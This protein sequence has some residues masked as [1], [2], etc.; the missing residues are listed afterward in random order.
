MC[1]GGWCGMGYEFYEA[2]KMGYIAPE[3][4]I[5]EWRK[6]KNDVRARDCSLWPEV[7]IDNQGLIWND[8]KVLVNLFRCS[9][10]VRRAEWW[11]KEGQFIPTSELSE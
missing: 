4:T 11:I 1:V 7:V 2:R 5:E 10:L 6:R 8:K 9:H 3:L